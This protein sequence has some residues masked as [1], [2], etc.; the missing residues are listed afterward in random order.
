M[1]SVEKAGKLPQ[2]NASCDHAPRT[3]HLLART[4]LGERLLNA[5]FDLT[6][7]GIEIAYD[8]VYRRDTGDVGLGHFRAIAQTPRTRTPGK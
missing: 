6:R 1:A 3:R 7:G 2:Q 4:W 5:K 8:A